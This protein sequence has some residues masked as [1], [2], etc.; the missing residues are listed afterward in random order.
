MSYKVKEV[1][2]I[3]GVSVRTLHH[4]DQIG[5]LKPKQ[6]TSAGYRIYTDSDLE[7]LQ[8]ILFFKELDF[9]LQDIKNILDNPSFDRKLALKTHRELLIEKRERIERIIKSVDNTIESIEGEKKMSK[10]DMFDGFD[11]SKI[12]E[13]KAK[14]AE[15][16][17][18]KYG[19][20]D[21]YKESEKKTGKYSKEDW[22][23]VMGEANEIYNKIANLMERGPEDEEV[24]KLVEEWRNHITKNFYNCTPEIFAGLGQ[25]YVYDERFTKNIDKVKPGLA[26]FLSN[27]MEIYCKNLGL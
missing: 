5:L 16:T 15:E 20:S 22:S 9:N 7:R 27:A 6:I 8:Q 24:Q 4:Y 11:M 17:K 12:E 23:R 18:E 14:Y 10:K 1:A 21:A 3:C 2:G 19:D 13:H 25:M 26:Q